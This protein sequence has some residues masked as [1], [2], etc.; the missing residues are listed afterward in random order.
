MAGRQNC[1]GR[2]VQREA[3]GLDGMERREALVI[4]MQ[5][6]VGEVEMALTVTT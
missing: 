5:G 6:T 1:L 3:V 4:D 2:A